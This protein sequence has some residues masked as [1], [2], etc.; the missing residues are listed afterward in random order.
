ML[1]S[2]GTI[3]AS[4]T[5]GTSNLPAD[6]E[7]TLMAAALAAVLVEYRRYAEHRS[8]HAPVQK[9]TDQW[10]VMGRMEQHGR[11]V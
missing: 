6:V 11:R 8:H 2:R 10:R 5:T 3:T 4:T 7:R 1:H 9:G